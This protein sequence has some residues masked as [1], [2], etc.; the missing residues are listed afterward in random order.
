[1]KYASNQIGC[2]GKVAGTRGHNTAIIPRSYWQS[3]NYR[4]RAWCILHRVSRR[5]V[6]VDWKAQYRP[7]WSN[8]K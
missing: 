8:A 3:T 2:S 5:V 6:S 4:R 1:M 7:L